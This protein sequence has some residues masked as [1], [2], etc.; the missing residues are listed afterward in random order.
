MKQRQP[1]KIYIP[2]QGAEDWQSLLAEPDK[3]WKTGYSAKALAYSWQEANGFP[4]CIL[5][6]FKKSGIKL[7]ED[8]EMLF[9]FPEHKVP[10]PPERGHPSQNDIFVLARGED[11]LVSIM[12][13][14]KVSEPFGETV[15]EW[16]KDAS[17][18]KMERLEYLVQE[19]QLPHRHI[20]DIRYQHLHRTA[21]AIIEAKRFKA[22]SALMLV[23]SFSPTSE[24]FEDFKHFLTLFDLEEVAP[25]S[26]VRAKGI[27]GISLYFGWVKGDNKYVELG[28]L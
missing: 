21:P 10:L 6:V 23:H 1:H 16:M 12:V 27:E 11:Q 4:Q 25:D 9:A 24:R 14:G 22:E 26:L 18:G 3:H 2:A 5:E 20:G 7:F 13:E 17:K 28:A 8:I 15:E 19:L